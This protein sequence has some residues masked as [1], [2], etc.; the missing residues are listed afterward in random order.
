MKP[1]ATLAAL[2]ERF[3]T[4]RLMGQRQVSPHTLRSYRDTFR[5]LLRFAHQR[6]K[7]PPSHLALEDMDEPLIAAFLEDLEQRRRNGARSRN[8]RLTAIRCFFRY[9]AYEAPTH[10]AQ[11]QR[12]LAM[13]GKRYVR[14]LVTFLTHPEIEA[15]LAAP[16]L[17]AWGGR[18]DRAW[19]LVALQTGL[20]VSEMIT[21]ERQDVSLDTG[22]H[23]H[24]IGKGRKERCTPLTQQAV[25][26]L[27]DWMREPRRPQTET[28]FPNARGGRLST[29]G[30]QY[31]LDKHTTIA[32][33]ACPSLQ[34]K[35]VT[36]HVLRHAAAMEL[37]Q[38]GVDRAVIALWLGHESVETTQIYLD[39]DLAMKEE[40]LAK[41][42]PVT[43]TPGRFRADD[44][45]L[46]FLASL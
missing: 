27:R 3:F 13:P 4:Q 12:I 7:K 21:L 23:V 43:V 5:L 1:A 38:A 46:A 17:G 8:L 42:T 25:R 22:A 35:R 14:R 39:A 33:H 26:V 40:V 31:L 37:L 34:H 41:T 18:R 2:V 32:R 11:I 10:A 30:V 29:D 19:L 24:C 44:Q 28:L 20:R 9:A 36:P 6:L 15:L 45:L 16:D